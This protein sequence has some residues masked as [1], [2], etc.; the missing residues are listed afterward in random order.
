MFIVFNI[1]YAQSSSLVD[2]NEN[3]L[4]KTIIPDDVAVSKTS[5]L[6]TPKADFLSGSWGVRFNLNGGIRLDNTSNY[7]WVAGAQEIVDNLPNVGHVITNFTHPAHGYYYTLRDNPY[8]DIA[9]DIHP[10][11][12]PT[13]ENEEIILDVI[14]IFKNAG[15]KVILY[16]NAGGPSNLQSD[17]DEELEI[18]AA[19]EAYCNANFDGD[20]G[21][22]WK[23]LA[24]GYFE[25]FKGL[26]DGYWI[27]N[28]S[29][30]PD[31]EV[32]DFV[33]MIR[34]VDPNVA[35]ATNLT[36]SYLKDGND[37][38]IEVDSDGINDEDPTDYNIFL[39][40]A[41]DP[42]MDFTA[43]HPT[44]LGQG[45]P[46]NSWAY[47]EFNF[48]LITESPWSSYDESKQTLKHY[49]IPIRERWSVASADLVFE[50]EQAYRFVRTFTDAL[51]TMTWSTTI[52]NGFISD[53]EMSIMQEIN[54]RMVQSTKPDFVP[55]VRPKGAFL[56]GETLSVTNEAPQYRFPDA[57][58]TCKSL[59]IETDAGYVATVQNP[60]KT[61]F[62]LLTSAPVTEQHTVDNVHSLLPAESNSKFVLS[63]SE[64][65][66]PGADFSF[67]MKMYSD[68]RGQRTAPKGSGRVI[69]RLYNSELGD[70]SA[71]NRLSI[72]ISDKI[73]GEWQTVS[74]SE[75]SLSDTNN[76]VTSSNVDISGVGGY[77]RI[78]ISASSGADIIEE[79]YFDDFVINPE[80]FSATPTIATGNSWVYDNATNNLNATIDVIG[81]GA[82]AE[83]A[84]LSP[85]TSNNTSVSVLK[86]TRGTV[87]TS[88]ISFL[89]LDFDYTR[90]TNI[91]F[92][93]FPVC[94]GDENTT[95]P[96]VLVRLRKTGED[97]GDTQLG[98][99]TITLIPNKWNEVT[100][101]MSDEIPSVAPAQNNLYDTILLLFNQ[102]EQ[103]ATSGNIYYI[104]ALQSKV[105]ATINTW[106]GS[107]NSNWET[108]ANWSLGTAPTLTNNVEIPSGLVKY[109]TITSTVFVNNVSIANSASLVF[110]AGGILTT[111]SNA[112]YNRTI[113]GNKWNLMA[114]PVVG[115]SYDDTWVTDNSIASGSNNNRGISIYNNVF[116]DEQTGY[117]R[118]FQSG[119][120]ATAFNPGQGY[121][122]IRSTSGSV[123]FTGSGFYSE[124]Q[125]TTIAPNTSNFSLVS[126]PFTAYLNLGD[127]F[128][129][130]D[131]ANLL[132]NKTI[133]VWNATNG[134]HDPKLSGLHSTYEIAHGQAFFVEAGTAGGTLNFDIADVSHQSTDTFQKTLNTKTSIKISIA[135]QNSNKR[136]AD[137]Y[138]VEGAT[139]GFD[140]GYEGE[141][142][143][144]TSHSFA[145]FSELL[146]GNSKKYQIQ[147]LPTSLMDSAII[148]LGVIADA[149]KS[150]TLNATVEN[151]PLGNYVYLEDRAKGSFTLLNDNDSF[152]FTTEEALNGIGRFYIHTAS[153]AL[154]TENEILESVCVYKLK[155]ATL[156]I[157]G[158][159]EGKVNV[160]LFNVLGKQSMN[161]SLDSNGVKNDISLPKLVKGIYIVQIETTKGIL[162]KK[163]I[164]D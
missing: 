95:D 103:A 98:S 107:V 48:P 60:N 70:S 140:N 31:V 26:A 57:V 18:K 86:L 108:A 33:A 110:S 88:G 138:F 136:N 8:V 102:T 32:S 51:A 42:Y 154:S 144:G 125:T 96:K 55:Y 148:P 59:A 100:V 10:A 101:D 130:N 74:F 145:I 20:T 24:K 113:E 82:T 36:K 63:L 38:K 94:D 84:Q 137:I 34:E 146:E 123:S 106:T 27:D 4:L 93:V 92:R 44:P 118:Y 121:G 155:N 2:V 64:P 132:A 30:L 111:A 19:W 21:L 112:T 3:V 163:I 65:I 77:D 35:I 116:S 37:N 72:V 89:G 105:T 147:S 71:G 39:L 47:E 87:S 158:L 162:N 83:V 160:K 78:V 73:G 13:I 157:I 97:G 79:L 7:D 6:T 156:R 135:D 114:S 161:I 127:F 115:E 68:N 126:N 17:S 133:W 46:P 12:V 69:I 14:S 16:V 128:A 25:R 150:I 141:L 151:F 152:S 61:G 52:T 43:G 67:S 90:A 99:S 54:N 122:I 66:F 159:S 49:F 139:T 131:T 134:V 41:N 58:N 142:F 164:L 5:A 75:A 45:A 109:P 124:S 153:K 22:G 129:D 50:E 76:S 117:W 149:S 1:S 85:D 11:M 62:N 53:D 23:T 91:K 40:E 104:D 28:L 9:N 81:N 119:G 56:V 15:K 143:G 29:S 80:R 120:S